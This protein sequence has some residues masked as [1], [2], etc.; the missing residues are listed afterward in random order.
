M[1][2]RSGPDRSQKREDRSNEDGPAA[3]KPVI[4]R[5]RKPSSEKS[6]GDVGNRVD[7]SYDPAVLVAGTGCL[8]YSAT[9]W[10]A[11]LLRE[12]EVG[13]IRS[14]LI[15]GANHVSFFY[16]RLIMDSPALDGRRDRVEHDCEVGGARVPPAFGD[17]QMQLLALGIIQSIDPVDIRW[18]LCNQC[19]FAEKW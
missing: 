5:V 11:E 9:I 19:T 4:Q 3:P 6:D 7:E 14:C 13:A 16:T 12:G 18:T 15:P 17:L 2:S 1:L 8:A 10:D